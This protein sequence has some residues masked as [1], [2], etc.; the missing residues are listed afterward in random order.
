LSLLVII[1]FSVTAACAL[2]VTLA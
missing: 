1:N 2:Y